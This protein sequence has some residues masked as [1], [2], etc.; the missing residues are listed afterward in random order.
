M[1][2][3]QS[4]QLVELSGSEP[5]LDHVPERLMVWIINRSVTHGRSLHLHVIAGWSITRNRS[6]I[7]SVRIKKLVD[8]VIKILVRQH[9]A[10]TLS[11]SFIHQV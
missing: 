8:Q 7:T 10:R 6:Q 9:N 4:V 5:E 1:N 2:T 11:G 3:G